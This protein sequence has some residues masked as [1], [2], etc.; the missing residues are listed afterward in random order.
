MRRIAS[1]IVLVAAVISLVTFFMAAGSVVFEPFREAF[2]PFDFTAFGAAL[3]GFMQAI[4]IPLIL[5]MLGLIG[6]TI[7]GND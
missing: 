6:L 3:F 1:F 7:S 5:A 4:S 2:N